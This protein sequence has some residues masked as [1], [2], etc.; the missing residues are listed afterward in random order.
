MKKLLALIVLTTLPI[1]AMGQSGSDAKFDTNGPMGAVLFPEDENGDVVITEVIEAPFSADTLK[2]LAIEFLNLM[3]QSDK[4]NVSKIN[5]GITK[6]TAHVNL[7]VGTRLWENPAPFA[8]PIEKPK[9]IVDFSI[10]LDFRDGKYKFTLTHFNTDRWRIKGDAEDQGPSN[11]I[12]WQRVN[13]ISKD[14]KRKGTR[15]EMIAEEEDAYQEEYKAVMKF[16]EGLR[17]FAVISDDF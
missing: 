16:V 9:S 15:A 7:S 8:P 11:R 10:V 4:T 12:H 13:S 2:G 1:L 6:V 17:A 14:I 5:E 3:D